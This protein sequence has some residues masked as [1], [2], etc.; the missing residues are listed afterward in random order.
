MRTESKRAYRNLVE[1]FE[2]TG[3]RQEDFADQ[4]GIS[5]A[6]VSLIAN[7]RRQPALDLALKIVE[8][9]NVPLETLV[10]AS[11]EPKAVNA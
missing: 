11:D 1:F 9:A 2:K 6:Y 3:T 5:S 10:P 8:L 7:G 4:L